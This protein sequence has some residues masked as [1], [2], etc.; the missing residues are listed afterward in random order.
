MKILRLL[1]N[2]NLSIIIISLLLSL[3][4]FAEEKLVDIW[5][6]DKDVTEKISEENLSVEEKN[7]EIFFKYIPK[8]I[9][10]RKFNKETSKENPFEVLKNLNLN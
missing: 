4:S 8:K 2:Q 1:N 6:L 3:S 5:N 7:E 9:D 10:K